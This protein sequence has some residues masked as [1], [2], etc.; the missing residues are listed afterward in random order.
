MDKISCQICGEPVHVIKT[1]L[2]DAHPEIDL[3]SYQS[4]YP[5]APLVSEKAQ[6]LIAAKAREKAA[7]NTRTAMAGAST[8][9]ASAAATVTRLNTGPRKEPLH[10][11]FALGR[12]KA[13]LNAQGNPIPIT[14]MGSHEFEDMIPERDTAYVWNIELL[15]T[16]LLGLELNIPTYYWGYHGSGKSTFW[17]QAC[18]HTRRPMIR[19]QHSANTEE[20]HVLGEKGANENGTFFEPGLLPLAMKYGWVYLADEYDY[21][22]PSVLAVYQPVLEGKPLIIKEAS[23]ESGW[24]VVHP[25]PDFRF[26]ATGNTNGAGDETGLYQGTVMGNAANYSRFGITEHV[27]YMDKK[28]ESLLIANQAGINKDDAEKL[29][30]FAKHIRDGF[31]KGNIGTTISP[32][33]LI[34]AAKLGLR[35]GSWR[36]GIERAFINRLAQ[37]D[38][39][40]ADGI[41]QRLFN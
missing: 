6:E 20:A 11:I 28:Q 22:H 31:D 25:H 37:V 41:A 39:Q 12:V 27:Q 34:Y 2:R 38:R 9:T 35:R 15:K 1:H 30:D 19:I 29:V 32:R 26:V 10:E 40:T 24:R 21:A 14:V 33:E 17:E 3:E 13:A 8:A 18:H 36:W 5:D 7:G 16:G 23:A 4:M